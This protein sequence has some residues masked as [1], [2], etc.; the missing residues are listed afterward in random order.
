MRRMRAFTDDDLEAIRRLAALG[1]TAAEIGVRLGRDGSTIRRVARRSKIVI[2]RHGSRASG[3]TPELADGEAGRLF[4]LNRMFSA[5]RYGFCPSCHKD[6]DTPI[7]LDP[8]GRVG[9]HRMRHWDGAYNQ[10]PVCRGTGRYPLN[11]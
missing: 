7:L 11:V 9:S 8:A 10:A 3:P 1:Q 6:G 5:T 2:Q 4:R